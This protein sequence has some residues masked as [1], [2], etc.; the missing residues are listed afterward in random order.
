MTADSSVTE[1]LVLKERSGYDF[2]TKFK[3]VYSLVMVDAND[4]C[5]HL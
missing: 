5:A 4:K 2:G 1:N 3:L